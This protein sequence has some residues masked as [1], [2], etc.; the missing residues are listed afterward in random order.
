MTQKGFEKK[1]RYQAM[2][3]ICRAMLGSGVISMDEFCSAERLLREKYQP[4]FLLVVDTIYFEEQ[5]IYTL[6]SKGE[7]LLTIM[8]S[9]AQEESRS[10]SENVTW[11]QR[12]RFADGKVSMPYKQFL[13]YRKGENGEPEIVSEE[14][15]TVR[16]IYHLFL[17]GM[18]PYKIKLT[19]EG[20]GI[21]SPSGRSTWQPRTI[22]SILAN[23]KYKGDAL[24]QKTFCTDFLTKK[25]KINEGEVPQYY[26]ENSHP[27]IVSD[28]VYEEVQLELQ[29]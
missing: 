26:V 27:A 13:G 28:E 14:A 24:L 17:N 9:L 4:I 16:Y 1:I 20:E 2:L 15:E 11:G 23:E 22:L 5:N 18:T 8:S 19:L 25:M 12:K 6:D 3:S 7:L 29:R 10:I 21:R